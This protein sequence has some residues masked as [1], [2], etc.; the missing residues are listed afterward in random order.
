[1]S[2]KG[3]RAADAKNLRKLRFH[4][5][6]GAVVRFLTFDLVANK[7]NI[8]TWERRRARSLA[9]VQEYERLLSK[10]REL[11]K[12]YASIEMQGVRISKHT[13]SDLP[14]EGQAD[15]GI[16]WESLRERVLDR[17]GL[18]CRERDGRC[19]GPL[20]IHHIVPLSKGGTNDLD[21]LVTICHYHHSLKHR[22]MRNECNGNI[23]C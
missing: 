15:Y 19:S 13:F 23:R 20:Q 4:K 11:D 14:V 16:D 8:E 7:R 1:M 2:E 22:H 18:E 5:H 3:F 12:L 10:A 9:D 17:D 6:F 21:N